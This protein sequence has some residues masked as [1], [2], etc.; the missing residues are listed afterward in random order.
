MTNFCNSITIGSFMLRAS[1]TKSSTGTNIVMTTAHG[2]FIA[3]SVDM[4]YEFSSDAGN[5]WLTASRP[6]RLGV[7]EPACGVPGPLSAVISGSSVSLSWSGSNFRLQGATSL[8][9]TV[10]W[11]NIL[12]PSPQTLSIA[13]P[14]HYFRL[15]CP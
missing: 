7:A 11:N 3:S 13:G 4:T 6:I 14:Y 5:T 12:G 15:I 2:T 8:I 9:P 1:L 10:V